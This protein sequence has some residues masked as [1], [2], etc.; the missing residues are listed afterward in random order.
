MIFRPDQVRSAISQ[1]VQEAARLDEAKMRVG[2]HGT[3]LVQY[4]RLRRS[5]FRARDFYIGDNR[6]NITDH[7]AEKQAV[8]DDS[9]PVTLTFDMTKLRSIADDYHTVIGGEEHQV[10]QFVYSGPLAHALI[11]ATALDLDSGEEISLPLDAD[12]PLPLPLHLV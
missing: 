12:T 2:F 6:E 7:Y 5:G 8:V 9:Y 11:A 1:T 4:D 10:G 3:S